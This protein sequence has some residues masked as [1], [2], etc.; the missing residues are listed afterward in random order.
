MSSFEYGKSYLTSTTDFHTY[1][2]F[3]FF[4]HYFGLFCEV[5]FMT[6]LCTSYFCGCAVRNLRSGPSP[7]SYN[8]RR[9]ASLSL[10]LSFPPPKKKN[11]LIAGYAA[12]SEGNAKTAKLRLIFMFSLSFFFTC[13][14]SRIDTW[15]IMITNQETKQT[16]E[17]SGSVRFCRLLLLTPSVLTPTYCS[18][19]RLNKLFMRQ[20]DRSA[21]KAFNVERNNK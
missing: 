11:R 8:P 12:R 21:E 15:P 2:F 3:C 6:C 14:I 9:R 10:L 18:V 17:L 5:M 1:V 13:T 20:L 16:F 19:P 7:F 4:Y